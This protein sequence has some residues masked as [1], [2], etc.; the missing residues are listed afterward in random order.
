MTGQITPAAITHHIK[1]RPNLHH[2]SPPILSYIDVTTCRELSFS[3]VVKFC[4]ELGLIQLQLH[5][6]TMGVGPTNDP[7]LLALI[8]RDLG[9][10]A[11]KACR[12]R[13]HS[14]NL[15]PGRS[16]YGPLSFDYDIL[17]VK[18]PARMG[19]D[20]RLLARAPCVS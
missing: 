13:I 9:N 3:C 16:V 18:R 8:S 6:G 5:F 2:L 17:L 1:T 10:S 20:P 4:V 14:A 19:E 11:L 15:E 12:Y 7:T